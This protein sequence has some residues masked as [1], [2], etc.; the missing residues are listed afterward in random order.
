METKHQFTL[1]EGTFSP[2]DAADV[3]FSLIGDKIKFHQLQMLGV[4]NLAGK[5]L[6]LSQK[7]IQS[8]TESKNLSKQLIIK[9]RDEGVHLQIN[10]EISIAL[11]KT[12][13]NQ[14]PS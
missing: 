11:V 2:A 6:V 9:A 8:L 3:L 4:Q 10:G 13:Q 5:D 7:R 1:V 12:S 14:L